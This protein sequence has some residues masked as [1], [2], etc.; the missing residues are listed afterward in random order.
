[1]IPG[2]ETPG[3]QI[4]AAPSMDSSGIIGLKL[5]LY[6]GCDM[7]L[8]ANSIRSIQYTYMPQ[9]LDK[10]VDLGD[11]DLKETERY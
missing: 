10:D 8:Y 1:V 11:F 5:T 6:V 3:I 7:C 9:Q 2:G 4:P